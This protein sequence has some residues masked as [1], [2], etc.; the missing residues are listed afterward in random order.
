M[1]LTILLR[2]ILLVIA[3]SL[4]SVSCVRVAQVSRGDVDDNAQVDISDITILIDYLLGDNV[5][6]FNQV[7][8]DCND[9]NKIDIND[10]TALI[11]YFLSG[12]W[13]TVFSYDLT[14]D[15]KKLFD[16]GL[17]RINHVID[18]C[19][20]GNDL[21]VFGFIT[22]MHHM[23]TRDQALADPTIPD[24]V[25]ADWP[26]TDDKYYGH[27]CEGSLRLLGA[28]CHNIGADAV[29]CGGDMSSGL[30]SFEQY[31]VM[32]DK[33]RQLFDKYIS[34]PHFTVD[35]NHDKRY[36]SRVRCRTNAEWLSYLKSF[37]T[38]GWAT[39]L[40]DYGR[41]LYG[42]VG[43]T[44]YV[45]FPA[46]K[47]RVVML[48]Q[49]ERHEEHNSY[50]SDG[51]CPYW[52]NVYRALQLSNPSSAG[53]WTVMTVS[54]NVNAATGDLLDLYY[55]AKYL[56]GTAFSAVGATDNQALDALNDGNKGKAVVGGI[57]GH[58]HFYNEYFTDEG[59]LRFLMIDSA[60]DKY[61]FSIFV[62]NLTSFKLFE[63]KVGQEG[64]TSSRS[65]RSDVSVS[66]NGWFEYD[67]RH[68]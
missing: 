65:Y 5:S 52:R 30:L 35:G 33:V 59:K 61:C 14:P 41:E 62:L 16:D 42:Y 25:K 15:E 20:Q 9:D 29:F 36:S 27:N 54:H 11:D 28:M 44:Y 53:E 13:P 38:P 26:S 48:S 6:L 24:A 51:L 63:V 57:F 68:N 32:M 17:L 47:V 1:R 56:D 60:S 31:E 66:P 50:R 4:L 64:N 22:D 21:M 37:N 8:A 55:M 10:V 34:V 2:L 46:H 7:N 58:R 3:A 40:E 39:Y 49:Y 18:L 19:G 23:Y 12:E 67:I 43:N 45:D